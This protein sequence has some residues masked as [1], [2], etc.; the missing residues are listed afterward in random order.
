MPS[1]VIARV[2]LA[3]ASTSIAIQLGLLY[4]WHLRLEEDVEATKLEIIQTKQRSEQSLAAKIDRLETK[5]DLV[6]AQQVQTRD[7]KE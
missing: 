6:L 2:S 1:S 3:L 7:G 4:P 5:L